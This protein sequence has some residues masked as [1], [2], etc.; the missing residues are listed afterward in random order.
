[1]EQ[2]N[3]QRYRQTEELIEIDRYT[4]EETDRD[5]DR[6]NT[7]R[8]TGRRGHSKYEKQKHNDSEVPQIGNHEAKI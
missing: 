4:E 6:Q 3:R 7:D 2:T 8:H 5:T 1:M